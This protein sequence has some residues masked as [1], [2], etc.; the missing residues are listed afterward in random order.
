MRVRGT[1]E[2]RPTAVDTTS[3]PSCV[4]YRTDIVRIDEDGEQG[5]HGW[6]YNEEIV[7]HNEHLAR[8]IKK[9][10]DAVLELAEVL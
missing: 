3:S 6:E 7:T 2:T 5:F 1:Q 10:Q 4:Y 9:T 8:E